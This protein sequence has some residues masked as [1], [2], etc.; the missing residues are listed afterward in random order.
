MCCGYSTVIIAFTS[1]GSTSVYKTKASS[2][3][4]HWKLSRISR[5]CVATRHTHNSSNRRRIC[6]EKRTTDK[7]AVYRERRTHSVYTHCN[8]A[9]CVRIYYYF[10]NT[11]NAREIDVIPFFVKCNGNGCLQSS[12]EQCWA[13]SSRR[14]KAWPCAIYENKFLACE[15]S[16][17]ARRSGLFLSSTTQ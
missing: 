9:F 8:L 6:D 10:R 2:L 5:S 4:A 15:I 3:C 1:N 14:M 11:H 16:G 13:S 7:R 17:R 12:S